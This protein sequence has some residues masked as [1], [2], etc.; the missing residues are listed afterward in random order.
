MIK[1]PVCQKLISPS[2]ISYKASSGFLDVDGVFH[3]D[4][5]IITHKECKENYI[6]NIFESLEKIIRDGDI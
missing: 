2:S 1:C 3:E 5:S 4:A 6:Y